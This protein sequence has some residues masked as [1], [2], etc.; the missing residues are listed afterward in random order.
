MTIQ[1]VVNIDVGAIT[2]SV[3][4]AVPRM[5]GLLVKAQA[6]LVKLQTPRPPGR[7]EGSRYKRTGFLF[8]GITTEVEKD[9]AFLIIAAFY[10]VFVLEH[11]SYLNVPGRRI[12]PQK[13]I[14]GAA[15]RVLQEFDKLLLHE[16]RRV[17]GEIRTRGGK[18][19]GA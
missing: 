19:G 4:R 6:K 12:E 17:E 15:A 14:S 11:G 18:Q 13:I 16:V 3:N 7:K 10:W 1:T 2:G 8:S 5:L 9:I